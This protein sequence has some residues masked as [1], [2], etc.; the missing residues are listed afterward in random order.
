MPKHVADK[1]EPMTIVVV[2]PLLPCPS[3]IVS[4]PP[5]FKNTPKLSNSVTL[6]LNTVNDASSAKIQFP[7]KIAIHI[8]MLYP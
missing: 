8:E 5:R 6:S 4:T 1:A 3:E 7:D 2:I